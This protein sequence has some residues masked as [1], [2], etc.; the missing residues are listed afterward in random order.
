MHFLKKIIAASIMLMAVLSGQGW[1]AA[2]ATTCVDFPNDSANPALKTPGYDKSPCITR[3]YI[4]KWICIS[5]PKE[6]CCYPHCVNRIWFPRDGHQPNSKDAAKWACANIDNR[7]DS[8]ITEWYMRMFGWT[9]PTVMGQVPLQM[10]FAPLA[11]G[12]A[13]SAP[14]TPTAIITLDNSMNAQNTDIPN[15]AGGENFNRRE[16]FWDTFRQIAANPA[17]RVLLY[18]LLIEIRRINLTGEHGIVDIARDSGD[19]ESGLA[20][21]NG[22]NIIV[23]RNNCRSITISYAGSFAFYPIEHSIKFS[24]TPCS[25]TVF[26]LNKAKQLT[27][28]LIR[29]PLDVALFHEMLHWFHWLRNPQRFRD[30]IAA[31][32]TTSS[33]DNYIARAYLGD[34]ISSDKEW[35]SEEPGCISCEEI[36][37]ILGSPNIIEVRAGEQMLLPDGSGTVNNSPDSL[38]CY[39]NG[40]DLS[41]NAYRAS[42]RLFMRWG[43]TLS[44]IPPVNFEAAALLSF[45]PRYKMAHWIAKNCCNNIVTVNGR[46]YNTVSDWEFR[47][48]K[49][50]YVE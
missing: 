5:L 23:I 2:I 31:E 29:V 47:G 43:H 26:S 13:E 44:T 49:A 10:G 15:P 46:F 21:G 14:Q 35:E 16:A 20:I 24:Y 28:Q 36:R 37:T 41:E 9:D 40:D 17:G 27:T 1:Y 8:P 39:C 25:L 6:D 34:I 45:I 3:Y 42:L 19:V 32:G 33:C 11:A 18:R 12:V 48:G 7:E 22:D 4:N 38:K 30:E 50:I